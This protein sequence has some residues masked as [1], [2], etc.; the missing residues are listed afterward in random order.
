MF[1]SKRHSERQRERDVENMEVTEKNQ[2]I[3]RDILLLL[4]KKRERRNEKK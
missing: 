4:Q 3:D 1:L 2:G